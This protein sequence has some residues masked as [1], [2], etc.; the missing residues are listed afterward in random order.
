MCGGRRLEL[1][2]RR[3][4]K[5]PPAT[6]WTKSS[7]QHIDRSALQRL[8]PADFFTAKFALVRHPVARLR[9]AYLFQRDIEQRIP[10]GVP[11][12]DWLRDTCEHWMGNTY[13]LDN[14]TRP[15]DQMV[16]QDCKVFRL[17]QG[18][19]PVISWLDEQVGNTDG[20]RE[21]EV[22]NSLVQKTALLGRTS[23]P[24]CA[25]HRTIC[26]R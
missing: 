13:D 21:I 8:F 24:V 9:R 4:L 26:E 12:S 25:L 20:P 2:D 14:H 11:F 19:V 16:P 6:C 18:L 17:E 1:L 7:S 15:M 5:H 10:T 23:R 3:F 22:F